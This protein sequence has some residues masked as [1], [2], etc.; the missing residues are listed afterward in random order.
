MERAWAQRAERARARATRQQ[1][2]SPPSHT[3]L[4]A[5]GGEEEEGVR[6]GGDEGDR[7]E[8]RLT[9]EAMHK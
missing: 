5:T 2:I 7:S 9:R 4:R 3:V 1:G 6:E 8:R